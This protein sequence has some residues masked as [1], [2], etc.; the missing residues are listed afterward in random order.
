MDSSHSGMNPFPL[1]SWRPS[2]PPPYLSPHRSSLPTLS[3]CN[4]HLLFK[5][6]APK[7]CFKSM[8][9]FKQTAINVR[10]R[11]WPTK[12]GARKPQGLLGASGRQ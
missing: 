6:S 7:E 9:Q 11:A 5:H 2:S 12:D 10:K 3:R 4:T 8:D 1:L